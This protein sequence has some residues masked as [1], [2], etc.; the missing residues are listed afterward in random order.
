MIDTI[1]LSE[2]NVDQEDNYHWT[3]VFENEQKYDEDGNEIEYVVKREQ[4]EGYQNY[5]GG[6]EGVIIKFNDNVR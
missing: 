5:T 1:T 3:G 4:T 6:S 2:L